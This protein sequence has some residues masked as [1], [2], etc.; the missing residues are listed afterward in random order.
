MYG[1]QVHARYWWGNL[2]E[3]DHVEDLGVGGRIWVFKKVRPG[4]MDWIRLGQD[5]N[6]WWALV[7]VVLNLWVP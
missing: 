4:G 2:R 5:R 3:K 6:R 1:E 7:N